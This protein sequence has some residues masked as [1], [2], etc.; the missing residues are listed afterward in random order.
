[1]GVRGRFAF[2]VAVR[3]ALVR[4][5]ILNEGRLAAKPIGDPS[6]GISEC[7]GPTLLFEKKK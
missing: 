6:F 7:Q 3:R 2:D 1:M 5:T 4:K